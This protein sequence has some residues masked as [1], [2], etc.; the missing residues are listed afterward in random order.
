MHNAGPGD[1]IEPS[2]DVR[3]VVH[4]CQQGELC[5]FATL[6]ERFQDR[7]YDLAWA[8]LRDEAEAED[9][10]QDTF[11]RV[12]ERIGR[13]RGESSFETW[14]VAVAVNVC[15]DRLRRRRV[16]QALSLEG[17]VLGRVE[18]PRW[19]ARMLGHGE[20]PAQAVQRHEHRRSLWD[21]V[22]RLDERHRL[23]LILRYHYGLSCDQVAQVLGLA[24]GTVYV[25]LS[26]GRRRL[27]QMLLEQGQA[28][29]VARSTTG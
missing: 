26:E 5:A 22:D 4:R 14:L 6:F 21:A 2:N 9:A 24:T 11:L 25:R 17:L 29:P 20:D 19:L 7:L 15:R 12:F 27:R 10:V 3:D 13:Y 18:A 23:P 16:R 8:I 28:N 1:T